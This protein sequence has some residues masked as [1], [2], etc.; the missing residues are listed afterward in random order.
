MCGEHHS[1]PSRRR[2]AFGSSPH[3]RGTRQVGFE[4]VEGLR[5]IPACAGNTPGKIRSSA[6]GAVH[7]RMCG[8][9][10]KAL[11]SVGKND[12]SSPH[13]RGTHYLK[14][15]WATRPRFIPACAGNTSLG[16]ESNPSVAVHPRMCGEHVRMVGDEMRARGSSPHVRG[17]PS[18]KVG[19]GLLDRFI[20]ACA[21]NTS[22]ASS[23]YFTMTVHPRMCGEH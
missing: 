6:L 10:Q 11:Y 4:Q 14:G 2:P 22:P 21:G 20:P 15:E 18:A 7:P 23:G 19:E 17:T 8:E 13:V 3:V 16:H 1:R 5:F 12:G 9:H